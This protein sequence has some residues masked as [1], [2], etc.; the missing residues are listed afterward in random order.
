MKASSILGMLAA[1]MAG[2]ASA[3]EPA[4]IAIA[5]HGG[6]GTISRELMTPQR[7]QAFRTK[8]EEAIRA[9]HGVLTAGGTSLE[10]V[11]RAIRILEDSPL[12]NAGKGAVFNAAGQNELDASIMDGASLDAG[13]VAAVHRVRNP[14]DLALRV[15][16]HSKHVMLI[17]EGAEQFAREQGFE[18]VDP[19]YFHT[20]DRWQELQAAKARE[21][22][23][24][25]DPEKWLSTVGAVALDRAGNLAAGTSTGG[26]TNKRWG[27]VGD[28][29]II[30]AGTYAN[31]DS[32]AVSATGTG[33]FFIRHVV[34]HS[35]CV[36]VAG[37]EDVA[38]AANA[39]VNEVLAAAGGDGG[40]IAMD[41]KGN[42]A[43]PHNTPGMH[44]ASIDRNE[45]L[46]VGIYRDEP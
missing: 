29:P 37:G 30:G 25:R 18:L 20:E 33:E 16:T 9:G 43:M 15:M 28:S 2:M 10:A 12:F 13:A 3:A 24:H 22:T 46:F 14:I 41:G 32:C 1:A 23:R 17:G 39:M 38:S 21:L 45:V 5:V 11:T 26:L 8:L 7:E 4:P 35:I 42:I 6:A 40:V 36:R 19:G 27:R 34:A 31:N 44:R